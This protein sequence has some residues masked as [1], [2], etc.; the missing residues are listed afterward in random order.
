MP[1]KVL[2]VYV[3]TQQQGVCLIYMHDAQG[4]AA[5]K[6]EICQASP[7]MLCYNKYISHSVLAHFSSFSSLRC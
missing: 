5:P 1:K 7:N 6:G 4:R 3:I 2:Q